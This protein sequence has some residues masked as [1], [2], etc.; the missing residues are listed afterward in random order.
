MMFVRKRLSQWSYELSCR[1]RQM[2]FDLFW[3]AL[4]PRPGSTMLNLGGD[5]PLLAGKHF[6]GGEV[7][8]EQ[9]EQDAR[10]ASLRIMTCNLIPE[11]MRQYETAY[12]SRGWHGLVADGCQL[13]FAD[14]SI[15]VVFSNAV[16]EHVTAADQRRM[17]NEIMRVGKSWFVTTPNFWCPMELHRKLPF[18]HFLPNN[19]QRALDRRFSLIPHGEVIELLSARNL[20]HLFPQSRVAHVRVTFW[21]ETLVVYGPAH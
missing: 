14:K 10:F 4:N 11:N 12:G 5:P 8:I 16:V 13:P 20:A 21:P 6:G 7:G 1:S 3:S 9:P 19:V 17:A 18:F 15:D 2:K